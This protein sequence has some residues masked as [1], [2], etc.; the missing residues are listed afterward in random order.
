MKIGYVSNNPITQDGGIGNFLFKLIYGLTNNSTI[1]PVFFFKPEHGKETNS[2]FTFI[3]DES[4][5]DDAIALLN[6]MDVVHWNWGVTESD[7][8]FIMQIFRSITIPIITTVHSLQLVEQECYRECIDTYFHDA[9]DSIKSFMQYYDLSAK[10]QVEFIERSNITVF[11][12]ENELAHAQRLGIKT[13]QTRVIYNSIDPVPIQYANIKQTKHTGIF[14]RL[15]YR[16][17]I[18]AAITAIDSMLDMTLTIHGGYGDLFTVAMIDSFLKNP[19]IQAKGELRGVDNQKRF[20]SEISLMFGN[21][22]Y[23]PFGY[24]HVESM[25]LGV[26]PIIGA[27]TGTVELFGEDYPFIVHDDVNDLKQKIMLYYSMTL[28]E[29]HSLA[30][31]IETRFK[32]KSIDLFL[33][34]YKHLYETTCLNEINSL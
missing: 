13:K 1:Q 33:S 10:N 27:G 20:F 21:S 15:V 25:Q 3:L 18:L 6:T 31:T 17:G 5:I 34:S 12:T 26:F 28:P 2:N 23:E 14:S 8:D 4:S 29:L 24:S 11:L 30:K 9:K 19:R 16:K 7:D 22:L 32:T